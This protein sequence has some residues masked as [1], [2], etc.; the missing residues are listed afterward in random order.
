MKDRRTLKGVNSNESSSDFEISDRLLKSSD[1]NSN[2]SSDDAQSSS[3][4]RPPISYAMLIT[5]AIQSSPEKQLVLS[6][7][8]DFVQQHYPYFK[9]AGAGWKVSGYF[10]M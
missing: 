3:F 9:D 2:S 6:D 7:I 4:T 5:E 8:Y 1:S 10:Y